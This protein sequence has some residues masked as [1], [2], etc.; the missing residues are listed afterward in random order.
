MTIALGEGVAWVQCLP[1]LADISPPLLS[2]LLPLPLTLLGHDLG[3]VF[4]ISFSFSRCSLVRST[5][6]TP[7]RPASNTF[8]NQ[9]NLAFDDCCFAFRNK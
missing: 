7:F 5:A 1:Y 4:N 2:F 6:Y 3:S 8:G 9:V